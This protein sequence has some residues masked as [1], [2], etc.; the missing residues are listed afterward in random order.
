MDLYPTLLELSGCK[1]LPKQT[2]DGRSLV[3]LIHGKTK[4]LG[5]PFLA[6]WYP[7]ANGHGTQPCQTILKDG[8]KLVH[9][10]NRNETELYRL[11]DDMEERD[12]LAKKEP[13]KARELLQTL[14]QWVK[15]TARK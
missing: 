10:M 5:R 3:S 12:D 7:H 6:W 9:W 1:Q 8:W 14:N 11:D 15:E 4:T 2:V 13:E